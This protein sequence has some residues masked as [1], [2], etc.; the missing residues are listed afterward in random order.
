MS[1]ISNSSSSSNKRRL[2]GIDDEIE[3]LTQVAN[4]LND[5]VH[6]KQF[7]CSL[8][9]LKM[10]REK[11][12]A[13]AAFAKSQVLLTEMEILIAEGDLCTDIERLKNSKRIKLEQAESQKD[14]PR[15]KTNK[16]ANQTTDNKKRRHSPRTSSVDKPTDETV[17]I[18]NIRVSPASFLL[19]SSQTSKTAVQSLNLFG[20]SPKNKSDSEISLSN[21]MKDEFNEPYT[22]AQVKKSPAKRNK[23]EKKESKTKSK[24]AVK[25]TGSPTE[26]QTLADPRSVN[27]PSNLQSSQ[28]APSSSS[29]S[30]NNVF[31]KTI[32]SSRYVPGRHNMPPV[33]TQYF[34]NIQ[35]N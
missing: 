24:H 5:F 8:M 34:S 18:P 30:E 28:M 26:K 1:D 19:E 12:K 7:Q 4:N 11:V 3:S 10:K 29:T 32:D 35:N 33:L 22:T 13:L 14:A 6:K 9:T 21:S 25:R 27:T 20:T 16:S 31:L 2:I 17:I 15:E 23:S